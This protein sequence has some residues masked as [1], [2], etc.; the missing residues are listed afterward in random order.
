[1][2]LLEGAINTAREHPEDV[3]QLIRGWLIEE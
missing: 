1:M 3:A 2:E